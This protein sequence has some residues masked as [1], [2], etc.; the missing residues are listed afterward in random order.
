MAEKQMLGAKDIQELF[1]V[2]QSKAYG[3]IKQMNDELKASNHIVIRGKVPGA[4]IEKRFYGIHV[5][6][7]REQE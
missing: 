4:Y 3:L 6:D 1:Q 7:C 2:S 5:R